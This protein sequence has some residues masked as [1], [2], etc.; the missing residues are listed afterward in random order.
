GPVAYNKAVMDVQ[1]RLQLRVSEI[2]MEVH[3]DEFPYW[4]RAERQGK[5]KK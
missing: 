1:E 5:S 3:E 4:R 2:D